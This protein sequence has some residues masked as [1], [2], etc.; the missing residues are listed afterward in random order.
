MSAEILF[1]LG[2]AADKRCGLK[3]SCLSNHAQISSQVSQVSKYI[4]GYNLAIKK[5]VK[6]KYDSI[7]RSFRPRGQGP[8]FIYNTLS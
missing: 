2:S 1:P 4:N 6:Y 7:L 3:G 5:N 8:N